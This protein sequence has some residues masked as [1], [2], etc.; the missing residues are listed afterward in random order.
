M[1]RKAGTHR[2]V[3]SLHWGCLR[4]SHSSSTPGSPRSFRLRSSST[5]L[6]FTRMVDARSSHTAPVRRQIFN[7]QNPVRRVLRR[8]SCTM[9]MLSS[10]PPIF[11]KNVITVDLIYNVLLIP[12][13]FNIIQCSFNSK[14][15]QV[16]H[17]CSFS[18]SF[19]LGF[20]TGY[21]I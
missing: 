13:S 7:L 20:I 11:L 9:L 18:Y 16:I 3:W 19:P 10:L 8:V 21:W 2:R 1:V 5:R 12:C 4:P 14:V 17:M 6:W 15:T